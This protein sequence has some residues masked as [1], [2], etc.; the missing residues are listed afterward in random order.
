MRTILYGTIVA[1]FL[2]GG[3]LDFVGKEYKL[4]TVAVLFAIANGVIFFWR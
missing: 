3:C 2:A 4:G 1:C